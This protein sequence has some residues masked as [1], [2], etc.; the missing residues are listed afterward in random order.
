MNKYIKHLQDQE[1][2]AA[3]RLKYIKSLRAKGE[4]MQQVA[5]KLGISRQRVS[6]LLKVKD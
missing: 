3:K 5:D 2:K 4:T 1:K 6:E